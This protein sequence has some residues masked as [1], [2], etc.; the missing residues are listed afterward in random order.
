MR[1]TVLSFIAYLI[2]CQSALAERRLNLTLVKDETRKIEL[3]LGVLEAYV[4]NPEVADIDVE[5]FE[6]HRVATIHAVDA[7]TS[8]VRF[9]DARNALLLQADVRV[10]ESVQKVTI[11]RMTESRCGIIFKCKNKGSGPWCQMDNNTG[12]KS[13]DMPKSK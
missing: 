12:C 10:K 3:P 9:Y 13:T 4:S 6:T 1:P 2:I 8:V 5:D 11:Y 7:G